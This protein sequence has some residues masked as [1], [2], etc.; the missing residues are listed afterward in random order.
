MH[1]ASFPRQQAAGQIVYLAGPS[2]TGKSKYS[3]DLVAKGWIHLEA[4]H[5]LS[6]SEITHIQKSH[7]ADL[8]LIKNGLLLDHQTPERVLGVIMGDKPEIA[9][10]DPQTFE[11][12]RSKIKACLDERWTTSGQPDEHK[13]QQNWQEVFVSMLEESVK[14]TQ[15]GKSIIIDFV[16]M[17][18]ERPEVSAQGLTLQQGSP[19]VWEYK[20]VQIQQF[21][22]YAPIDR[23]AQNIFLRNQQID[24]KRDPLYV[25]TQY[26]E[27]F[28]KAKVGE[29][30]VGEL[31][32]VDLA[33]WIERFVKIEHFKLAYTDPNTIDDI[34]FKATETLP[35]TEL[36]HIQH[37]VKEETGKLFN[38]MGI[39]PSDTR[40]PLTYKTSSAAKPTII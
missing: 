23:L 15:A 25:L 14:A 34:L 28:V 9:P 39:E 10:Q 12:A 13:A 35:A 21:L 17:L 19:N 37:K 2:S 33:K 29:D 32:V 1:S 36:A 7:G 24:N 38:L 3:N 31:N 5:F 11:Q 22:K 4:D 6:L 8:E 20:G 40:I 18:N 27:R 30:V 16:G 26:G